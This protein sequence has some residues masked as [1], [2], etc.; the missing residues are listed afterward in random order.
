[1]NEIIQTVCAAKPLETLEAIERRNIREQQEGIELISFHCI[2][3]L[4]GNYRTYI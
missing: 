2:R 1:M 3:L 4:C